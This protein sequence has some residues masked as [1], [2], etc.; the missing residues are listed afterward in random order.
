MEPNDL[1]DMAER[2]IGPLGPAIVDHVLT[3]GPSLM[4][5]RPAPPD[6]LLFMGVDGKTVVLT[7]DLADGTVTL[8]EGWGVDEAAALFWGRVRAI[9]VGGNVVTENAV[10][11]SIIGDLIRSGDLIVDPDGEVRQLAHPDHDGVE[12]GFNPD[13]EDLIRRI[14]SEG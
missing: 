9:G 11:R 10:L 1:H 7:V 8:A 4:I 5:A 14:A 13:Q 12:G 2:V 3:S 6:R